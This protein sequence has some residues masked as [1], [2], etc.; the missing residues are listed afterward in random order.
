MAFDRR[1]DRRA[2]CRWS[3]SGRSLPRKQIGRR[4]AFYTS[5]RTREGWSLFGDAEAI[6]F[7][8]SSTVVSARGG[9]CVAW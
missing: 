4:V 8:D 5:R 2:T 3:L 6:G 1:L 9:L 7:S